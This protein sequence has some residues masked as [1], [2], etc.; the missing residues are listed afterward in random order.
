MTYRIRVP[1][2]ITVPLDVVRQEL[3]DDVDQASTIELA[4]SISELGLL[5]PFVLTPDRHLVDGAR[6]AVAAAR[7]GISEIPVLI[8][9][10]RRSYTPAQDAVLR[11]AAKQHGAAKHAGTA[12]RATLDR[13]DRVLALAADHSL[14]LLAR[15]AAA[16]ALADIAAGGSVNAALTTVTALTQGASTHARYP[17]LSSLEPGQALRMAAYL[18]ALPPEQRAEELEVLRVMSSGPSPEA[19]GVYGAMRD[20]ASHVDGRRSQ[21][22]QIALATA[23]AGRH[24]T[25]ALRERCLD[26]AAHLEKTAHG[27]RVALTGVETS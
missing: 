23:A 27:I 2:V 25:P 17:E 10:D 24:L 9:G 20:L 13:I 14:P 26:V 5:C 21:E 8:L 7:L 18:D 6:R 19:M 11:A 22:I 4:Q 3:T 15:Q 16:D 12:S 1:G